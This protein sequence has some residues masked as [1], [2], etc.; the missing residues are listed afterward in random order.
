[1]FDDSDIKIAGNKPSQSI[2]KNKSDTDDR[3]LTAEQKKSAKQLGISI[4]KTFLKNVDTVFADDNT[5]SQM[6]TQRQLLLS[7]TVT[8]TL[9]EYC[10][11]DTV[12]GIAEKSFLDTLKKDAI[13]TYNTCSDTGAFSFYYLAYRRKTEI[14]RRMGQTF[15]MLCSHD[16]DPIYQELGEALYCW[17]VSVVKKE[18]LNHKLNKTV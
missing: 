15:A 7:F 10:I 5:D 2:N 4:A 18:I 8:V 1:M 17:F 9:D 11:N 14:D 3:L 6:L 12:S 13:D 16:G